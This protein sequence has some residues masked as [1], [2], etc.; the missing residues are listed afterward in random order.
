ML[1]HAGQDGQQN[2]GL[3]VTAFL[4]DLL[5]SLLPAVSLL[6]MLSLML[7]FFFLTAVLTSVKD[8]STA[9]S[10]NR[11]KSE[12][13]SELFLCVIPHWLEKLDICSQTYSSMLT[14]V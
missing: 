9:G 2:L 3:L 7:F 11:A 13:L 5:L 10:G 6:V 1:W 14:A 12:L 8:G 4:D